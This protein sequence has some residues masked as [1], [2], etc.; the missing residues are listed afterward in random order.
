MATFSERYPKNLPGRYYID[1]DC[2]DCDLCRELAPQNIR[3]D[4]E[5]GYSYV[6][7]QPVTPEEIALCEEGVEGCPTSAVGNDGDRFDW[8]ATSIRDWTKYSE[9]LLA[10]LVGLTVTEPK[11]PKWRRPA[12]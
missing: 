3:R 12:P 8:R 10:Y 6:Y 1:A 7:R 2:T 9:A 11:P 4:D 5:H